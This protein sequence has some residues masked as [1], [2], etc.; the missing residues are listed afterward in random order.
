[1]GLVAILCN[2]SLPLEL[3]FFLQYSLLLLK[4]TK[5]QCSVRV[6][7]YLPCGLNK[8][9]FVIPCCQK[10]KHIW[11]WLTKLWQNSL[12]L[13]KPIEKFANDPGP[14]WGIGDWISIKDGPNIPPFP[15]CSKWF[16]I[17]ISSKL[18][19]I[20]RTKWVFHSRCPFASFAWLAFQH[21]LLPD[22][23]ALKFT[24]HL[25]IQCYPKHWHR[26]A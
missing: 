5:L 16:H 15:C 12:Y 14:G 26:Y 6:I 25:N 3:I 9:G 17:P 1:M 10:R 23:I 4:N 13:R 24:S 8:Y 18:D 19:I 20:G 21:L 11:F 2:Q 22:Y 7:Y